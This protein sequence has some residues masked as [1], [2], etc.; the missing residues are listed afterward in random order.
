MAY[1]YLCKVIKNGVTLNGK[2]LKTGTV[3]TIEST[4]HALD[5]RCSPNDTI[6]KCLKEQ[7]LELKLLWNTSFE[8]TPL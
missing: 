3:L 4:D 2:E 1:Q 7:G 5:K 6:K 8:V